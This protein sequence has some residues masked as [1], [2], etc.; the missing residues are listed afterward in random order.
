MG[1]TYAVIPDAVFAV[2]APERRTFFV[3]YDRSTETLEKLVEKLVW[4]DKGLF[5]FPFE[6]VLIIT[7]RTRRLDVLSREL[8]RKGVSVTTLA[9]TMAKISE[10]GV[11]EVPFAD[12]LRGAR[13][14]VLEAS[15][16]DEA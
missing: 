10:S 7:E 3:E 13:R 8:R 15:S 1:W 5:E 11:F 16:E 12:L 4:Y 14:R 2:K 6:A 9:S